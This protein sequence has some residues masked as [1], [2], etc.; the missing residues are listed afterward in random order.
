MVGGD[1]QRHGAVGAG[2]LLAHREIGRHGDEALQHLAAAQ[3]HAHHLGVFLHIAKHQRAHRCRVAVGHG[4]GQQ[5]G[6]FL[7]HH[8]EDILQ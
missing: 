8:I 4:A 3:Q 1:L 6:Q 7:Q 5:A 2:G